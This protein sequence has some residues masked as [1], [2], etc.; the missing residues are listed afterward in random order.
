MS[1]KS[2]KSKKPRTSKQNILAALVLILIITNIV[3]LVY[4]MCV[5]PSV[6]IENIPLEI[7][8]V[9][10]NSPL[11]LGKPLTLK[12]YYVIS[13]GYNLLVSHP[14]LFFNNSLDN[15]NYVILT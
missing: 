5:D 12:G 4:F 2:K 14:L 13:A 10:A 15:D 6:P 3:T 11:Y 9:A 7:A 8:D 1:K